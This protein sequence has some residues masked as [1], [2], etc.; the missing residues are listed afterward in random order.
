[1]LLICN[2]LTKASLRIWVKSLY[3]TAKRVIGRNLSSP[4]SLVGFSMSIVIPFF[5]SMGMW[6]MLYICE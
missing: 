3:S 4:K 6:L 5:H 2:S 1:M